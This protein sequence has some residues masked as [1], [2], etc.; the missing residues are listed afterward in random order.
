MLRSYSEQS[1]FE[2]RRIAPEKSEKSYFKNCL[3]PI[4]PPRE[5]RRSNTKTLEI[6]ENFG[7]FQPPVSPK[8]YSSGP[9]VLCGSVSRSVIDVFFISPYCVVWVFGHPLWSRK[10]LV[11]PSSIER[12]NSARLGCF[13]FT[14]VFLTY[15]VCSLAWRYA[16]NGDDQVSHRHALLALHLFLQFDTR[17]LCHRRV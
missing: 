11:D 10:S 2:E 1:H 15:G 5:A 6:I 14:H 8:G 12:R 13:T 4:V 3:D 9:T 7:Q 16:N 17:W